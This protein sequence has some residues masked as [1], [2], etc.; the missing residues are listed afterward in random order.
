MKTNVYLWS[1]LPEFFLEWEIFQT[2]FVE[3]IGTYIFIQK[4]FEKNVPFMK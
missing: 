4:R 1:Y 3:K 2:K